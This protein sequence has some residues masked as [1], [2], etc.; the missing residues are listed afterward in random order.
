MI[1]E[2]WKNWTIHLNISYW[3]FKFQL[4]IEV[5]HLNLWLNFNYM[6]VFTSYHCIAFFA[7]HVLKVN[8]S[9]KFP[10]TLNSSNSIRLPLN[11]SALSL[12]V[13]NCLQFWHFLLFCIVHSRICQTET[14]KISHRSQILEECQCIYLWSHCDEIHTGQD[15]QHFGGRSIQLQS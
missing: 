7:P 8:T 11:Q 14:L 1:F 10:H 9:R 13:R 4:T 3:F 15:R 5:R 6:R 2:K 12:C